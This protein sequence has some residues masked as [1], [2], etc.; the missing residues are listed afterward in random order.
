IRRCARRTAS[1]AR[2]SA[3]DCV[4]EYRAASDEA[5][6]TTTTAATGGGRRRGRASNRRLLVR[7]N[8]DLRVDDVRE[9]LGNVEGD[10]PHRAARQARRGHLLPCLAAVDAAVDGAARPTA[11]EAPRGALPLVHR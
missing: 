5:A 3:A 10:A 4:T 7:R 8:F 9:V 1:S 11:V 6:A 2:T